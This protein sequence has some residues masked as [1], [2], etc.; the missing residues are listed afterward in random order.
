M[1][2]AY[3]YD[4]LYLAHRLR[5]HPER[6]E[7][8]ERVLE[9]LEQQGVLDRLLHLDPEPATEGQIELVHS[10]AHRQNVQRIARQ[11]GGHLDADTYVNGRSYEIA[12]LAAGG[13]NIAVGAVLRDEID[14]AFCLVRP[15]GHHATANRGMGF[16]LF[17]NVAIGARV[18]QQ[19]HG[20][21][22]VM[23]VDFD[24]HHG[25][26]I[27][28]IFIED[29]SVFYFSTHQYPHYPGTG[30]WRETG[31]GSG[32]RATINVPLPP[33]VGDQGYQ[34]VFHSLLQPLAREFRPQLILVSAGFDAHW[35][36]PLASM[37][38]SLKG[39]AH[40]VQELVDLATSLCSGSIVF[41][42]EGGYHLEVLSHGV[43]NAF[44]ALLREDAIIDP[45]GPSPVDEK[46]VDGL[47]RELCQYHGIIN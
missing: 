21:E 6:P 34:R 18:A 25:N 29:P 47:I 33:G 30:H 1:K 26:G 11:G 45:L 23:I 36:D 46:P 35:S 7:R 22:R 27:Q 4:P 16:C 2:T 37:L 20:V 39:Y 5:G 17:N 10:A 41:A 14:N 28:D 42:L 44:Y 43:L 19:E 40:L 32:D 12:L 13:V 24:V 9:T 8:L 15:P 31:R 3:V 38:L